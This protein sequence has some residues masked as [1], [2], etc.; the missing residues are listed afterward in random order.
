MNK[1]VLFIFIFSVLFFGLKNVNAE[2][3]KMEEL[4]ERDNPY[5]IKN[6]LWTGDYQG[7]KYGVVLNKYVVPYDERMDLIKSVKSSNNIATALPPSYDLRN[8]NGVNYVTPL[9]DQ[10][11]LGLCWAFTTISSMET[12]LLKHNMVTSSTTFNERQLDYA[13]A[14]GQFDTFLGTPNF[15]NFSDTSFNS[16]YV[17]Y[18]DEEQQATIIRNL[19]SGGN[20]SYAG[21]VLSKGVAPVRQEGS[22]TW[23]NYWTGTKNNERQ[24]TLNQVFNNR[25]ISYSV[26][27]YIEYPLLDL[28]T[29]SSSVK[30]SYINKIKNQVMENG[31]VYVSTAASTTDSGNCSIYDPNK[32]TYLINWADDECGEDID[33]NKNLHAM[34]IIGWDDN[35]TLSYCVNDVSTRIVS[36]TNSCNSN[37]IGRN[38]TG[39][40]ILKNSWGNVIPY[41]YLAY[42]SYATQFGGITGMVEKDWSQNYDSVASLV[43]KEPSGNG[44]VYTYARNSESNETLK[45]I[46]LV[47]YAQNS[48]TFTISIDANNDGNF[49]SLG[50]LTS[51]I[52]G[53]ISLSTFSNSVTLTSDTFRIKITGSGTDYVDSVSI[54]TNYTNSTSTKSI[55]AKVYDNSYLEYNEYKQMFMIA[56]TARNYGTGASFSQS[57]YNKN[58]N[59]YVNNLGSIFGFQGMLNMYNDA[60]ILNINFFNSNMPYGEYEYHLRDSSGNIIARA[61]FSIKPTVT[62]NT[63]KIT[64]DVGETY[65]GLGYSINY[66][67]G[68]SANPSST[69]GY[70]SE[71]TNIATFTSG[72]VRGIASGDTTVGLTVTINGITF[73]YPIPVSV[74][75]IGFGDYILEGSY[76]YISANTT[77]TIF[78]DNIRADGCTLEY[79]PNNIFISTG[80]TLT[81][82]KNNVVKGTYTII[83]LGDV[84]SDGKISIAD[85]S[86]LYNFFMNI[87]QI[88]NANQIKAGDVNKDSRIS[89]ADVSRLY[90]Y[91]MNIIPEL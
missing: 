88:D 83:V 87:I 48:K 84:N 54:F 60:L 35:Y 42:D 47:H 65:S 16:Y 56:I 11:T 90:N 53:M 27:G 51:D 71:N 76:L 5:T 2:T 3:N 22:A 12:Y 73:Y 45:R 74:G 86:R 62:Y 23:N 29:A 50:T 38:V 77:K 75:E 25:D 28:R 32:G 63:N 52:P 57:V 15:S 89:I 80:T 49:V 1:K 44:Y 31:S 59:S 43:G 17:H 20:F 68:S 34:S 66:N 85:V 58:T 69:I 78:E 55:S 33:P 72:T 40:W 24:L 19:G 36:S 41:L 4:S 82:R 61:D 18:Y 37:E 8:V 30:T 13:T 14:Y 26:T 46:S 10:A 70:R 9:K 81:I 91:F 64:L 39:A 6:P 21:Y 7:S 79:S 67:N